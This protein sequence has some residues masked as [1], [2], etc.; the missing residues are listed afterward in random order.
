MDPSTYPPSSSSSNSNSMTSLRPL[1]PRAEGSQG[2]SPSDLSTGKRR[3]ASNAC[4]ECRSHKTKVRP[5]FR[6]VSVDAPCDQ[7]TPFCAACRRRGA[8]D[9][10]YIP[11]NDGRRRDP[12]ERLRKDNDMMKVVLQAIKDSS[13]DEASSIVESLRSDNYTLEE[14]ASIIQSRGSDFPGA[15]PSSLGSASN[16]ASADLESPPKRTVGMHSPESSH[17]YV[18]AERSHYG[19]ADLELPPITNQHDQRRFMSKQGAKL[20]VFEASSSTHPLDDRD[21][22]RFPPTL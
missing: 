10:V 13:A 5:Y 16:S 8:T 9:C 7:G 4:T 21:Y 20:P 15:S 2:P 17:S 11:G 3:K 1:L 18:H 22:R 6:P 12:V 19:E 14:L